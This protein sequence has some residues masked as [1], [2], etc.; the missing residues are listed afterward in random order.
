MLSGVASA[1]VIFDIPSISTLF[2][3][4][5]TYLSDSWIS[6]FFRCFYAQSI[7]CG[8]WWYFVFILDHYAPFYLRSSSLFW[9]VA[10]VKCYSTV[11]YGSYPQVI[12]KTVDGGD[13]K[14]TPVLLASI[15]L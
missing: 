5:L 9:Q 4:P 13:P 3:D 8:N 14:E 6:A 12:L 10:F 2:R 11:G 15:A 1:T 7:Y